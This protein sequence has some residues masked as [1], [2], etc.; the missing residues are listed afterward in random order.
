MISRFILIHIYPVLIGMISTKGFFLILGSASRA[1]P[2]RFRLAPSS[3]EPLLP[4]S[5]AADA[6]IFWPNNCTTLPF[7][8]SST[9]S[10]TRS[11]CCVPIALYALQFAFCCCAVRMCENARASFV[12]SGWELPNQLSNFHTLRHAS[13]NDNMFSLILRLSNSI[14]KCCFTEYVVQSR[15]FFYRTRTTLCIP[16]VFHSTRVEQPH[17]CLFLPRIDARD[18][19]V[20][21]RSEYATNVHWCQ[22]HKKTSE[23][24]RHF[25]RHT[26]PCTRNPNYYASIP[27][28]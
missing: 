11:I 25:H 5:L 22:F 14:D 2:V 28:S 3:N 27:K 6:V 4:S 9:T 13:S 21:M 19:V 12:S 20:P 16:G 15:A 10:T 24:T 18:H 1:P 23:C 26:L 17:I 7:S 8:V